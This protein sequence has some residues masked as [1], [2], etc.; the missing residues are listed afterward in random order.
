MMSIM[1]M[2]YE[3]LMDSKKYAF[4]WDDDISIKKR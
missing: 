1:N 3:S 2:L 4:D